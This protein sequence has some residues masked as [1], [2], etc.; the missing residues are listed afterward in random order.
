MMS[1]EALQ[2]VLNKLSNWLEQLIWLLPNLVVATLVVVVFW[3]FARLIQNLIRQL[4]RRVST[5][6]E[7]NRLVASV[8]SFAILAGGVFIALGIVGLD[9]TVTSLLA[10]AGIVA[11]AIGLAFQ[12]IATNFIAGIFISTRRPFQL[13]H[14]IETNNVLGTVQSI[15]LRSIELR[16]PQGQIVLI[17]NKEVF[18]KPIVNYTVSQ[19][20]RIDLKVDVAYSEDLEKV[21]TIASQALQG[22]PFRQAAQPV[23]LFYEEFADSSIKLAIRLWIDSSQQNDFLR[24]RSEAIEKI[25]RAFD[26]HDITIPSSLRTFDLGIAR[27]ERL[28]KILGEQGVLRSNHSSKE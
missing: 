22:V 16:T 2:K 9:K 20:R 3:F 25:K 5:V 27:S 28:L 4:L 6:E 17:P 21:K 7:M 24:A 18:E 13:N 11:L 10:G 12:N 19:K 14:L 1:G 15:S 8:V 26:E 23:E